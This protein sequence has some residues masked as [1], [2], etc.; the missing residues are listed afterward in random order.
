VVYVLQRLMPLFMH[1]CSLTVPLL[2]AASPSLVLVSLLVLAS[3]LCSFVL[4]ALQAIVGYRETEKRDWNEKNAAVLRRV[5]TLAFAPGVTQLEYVHVLDVLADGV[6][7]PH[8]DSVR[9]RILLQL[10]TSEFSTVLLIIS[11]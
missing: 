7:R 3:D 2:P 5:R 9:V 4:M 8:I 1:H 6:I 11:W 10:S